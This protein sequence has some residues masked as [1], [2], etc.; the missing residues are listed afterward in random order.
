MKKIALS[1]LACLALLNVLA[2]NA[3]PPT[4]RM[5]QK[6][7]IIRPTRSPVLYATLSTGINNNTGILGFNFELPIEKY[8]SLEL[9][10]G[11][12]S[13]GSKLYLGG[14]YYLQPRQTGWAFGTG[15]TYN[16][17]ISHYQQNMETI[18]GNGPVELKLNAQTNLL[19]AAYRYWNIGKHYN[20][21]FLELGW[22][23]SLNGED[24]YEQ[25]YGPP[26]TQKS[27]DVMNLISP[28]GLIIGAGFSFGVH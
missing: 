12:S 3:S 7:G 24:K 10:A 8:I 16:T 15:L 18:D 25:V 19:F 11:A 27:A 1:L 22:S 20:R 26:L 4:K 6:D 17:G 28:G 5:K 21:F 14:K 13:W 9:G 2:Q 23:V